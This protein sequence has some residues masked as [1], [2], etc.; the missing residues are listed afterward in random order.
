MK[1]YLTIFVLLCTISTVH[2]AHFSY[3]AGGLRAFYDVY[4]WN[5]SSLDAWSETDDD[6]TYAFVTKTAAVPQANGFARNIIWS[7]A[8]NNSICIRSHSTAEGTADYSYCYGRGSGFGGTQNSQTYGIFYKIMPDANEQ[9]GDDVMVYYNDFVSILTNGTTYLRIG[10]PGTMD[11]VAITRG[12]LPP[13]LTEPDRELEVLSFPKVEVSNSAN[14][15]WYSGVHA[16]PAQI[17]DVIGIFAQNSTKVEG[18]GFLQGSIYSTHT[19]ILTVR[20]VLLGDLDYDDDVDFFD[21]AILANNWL[22]DV[23]FDPPLDTT[24][25]EPNPM[26]WA[27]GGEPKEIGT[28]PFDISATMT[29][30]IA[31][32]PSG[33]VQYYFECTDVGG[34]SSGWQGSPSY[35]VLVGGSGQSL[36]FT[37]KARDIHGNETNPSDPPLPAN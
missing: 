22:V 34:F 36:H 4:A 30:A 11:H 8:G 9:V 15:D 27:E 31:T 18:W 26:E 6:I 35:T 24:P 23:G 29:A 13:G 3:Y 14:A 28:P 20:P 12:Q 2:G 25:P 10:G 7:D 37:V 17:G 33:G 32:D 5:G 21:L 19:M 16:F 1:R